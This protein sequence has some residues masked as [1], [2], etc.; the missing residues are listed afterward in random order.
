[1]ASAKRV[2]IARVAVFRLSVPN[3]PLANTGAMKI[4]VSMLRRVLAWIK[5]RNTYSLKCLSLANGRYANV[6]TIYTLVC[7]IKLR[8]LPNHHRCQT[9]ISMSSLSPFRHLR[10]AILNCKCFLVLESET[11]KFI[12]IRCFR[13]QHGSYH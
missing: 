6:W 12:L 5:P 13:S 3:A 1:M 11:S 10:N 8:K 4:L 2:N 7:R 9:M